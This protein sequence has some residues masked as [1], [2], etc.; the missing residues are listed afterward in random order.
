MFRSAFVVFFIVSSMFL[1]GCGR[2]KPVEEQM[3][4]P[5]SMEELIHIDTPAKDSQ[6]QEAL[7][8][9]VSAQLDPLPPQGPYK[10]TASEIQTAL[11][12]ANFYTGKVDGK[13][14]PM[15]KKAIEEFQKANGLKID[16]K[17]GPKTW[18]ALS[19]YLNVKSTD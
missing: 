5:L 17:V 6:P 2:K 13:I 12:N 15:S 16:G 7:T 11:K 4:K 19:K 3:E 1:L 10:P 14:G 8:P 18:G 9:E